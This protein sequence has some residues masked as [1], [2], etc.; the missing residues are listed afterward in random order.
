M[1][2]RSSLSAAL[3]AISPAQQRRI[4]RAAEAYLAQRPAYS[5]LDLRFDAVLLMPWRLPRHIP[6]AGR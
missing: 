4:A 3:E 6:A 1:K 5:G 2:R